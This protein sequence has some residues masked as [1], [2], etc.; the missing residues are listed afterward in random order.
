MQRMIPLAAELGVKT[1]VFGSGAA[2]KV[3][4]GVSRETAFADLRELVVQMDVVAQKHGVVVAVE[5]LN[6]EETN[7][8]N[9]F[10]EG[11]ELSRGLSH[12]GTMVDNY[13]VAAEGQD[14]FDITKNPDAMRHLHIAL[15]EGR[16]V[17]RIQDDKTS[18]TDFVNA[19]KQ[20]GYNGMIS[21]EGA[22]RADTQAGIKAEFADCL[23]M[24]RTLFEN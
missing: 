4:E 21:V 24:L 12:V 13:H 9:S 17:P 15:P 6:T 5:P 19:V 11:V 1:M 14:F 16:M 2:R 3:P 8:I 18:Y 7:I 23:K 10:N 22:L 20:I